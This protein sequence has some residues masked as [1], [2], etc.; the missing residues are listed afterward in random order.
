MVLSDRAPIPQ[1]GTNVN[2]FSEN[3]I[4]NI[5]SFDIDF[6]PF[7]GYN[8][9]TSC[10]VRDDTLFITSIHKRDGAYALICQAPVILLR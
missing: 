2:R 1:S 10:S 6:F 4:D 5:F 3:N 7:G 8:N 9:S